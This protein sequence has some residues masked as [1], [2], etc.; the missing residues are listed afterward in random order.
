MSNINP[1]SLLKPKRKILG[2]SAMLLPFDEAGHIDWLSYARLLTDTVSA[3]L[4]PAIN[5]DTGYGPLLSRE[6]RR[7]VLRRS[8]D[9]LKG[10][11]FAAGAVVQD[12]PG[13]P[14]HVDQ[15]LHEMEAIEQAGGIPVICQSYGLT[16]L[17][18]D[19]LVD[20]YRQMGKNSTCFI[21]FELGRMFATFGRIYSLEI[22]Q[23][24]LQIPSCMGAK[25]SSLSRALEWHRL[26]LRDKFRPEFHVFTGNDLAIDM[27]MYGSDYLLGLSAFAPEYFAQR[28]AY[29]H[30]GDLRFYGLNDT[31]QYLGQFAFRPPVPAYKHTAAQFLHLRGKIS[32]NK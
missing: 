28:D 9:V 20:A 25:H 22:Y 3:G 16:S 13:Q 10:C 14:F 17:Q 26:I 5:M 15:Y 29:W 30:Q 6:E 18:D 32:S 7:E 12:Q 4:M 27:V 2:I 31:L 11:K 21:A 24:L 23:E 1:A 8:A 19:A